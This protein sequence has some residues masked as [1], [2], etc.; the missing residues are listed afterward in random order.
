MKASIVTVKTCWLLIFFFQ[1]SH[2]G[3]TVAA[4][5][6]VN[7]QESVSSAESKSDV[8]NTSTVKPD[9]DVSS[10]KVRCEHWGY[11]LAFRHVYVQSSFVLTLQH[12]A[13]S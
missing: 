1:F 8:K 4:K 11:R 9:A 10:K 2:A 13:F 5:D 3:N 6:V 12:G 7:L